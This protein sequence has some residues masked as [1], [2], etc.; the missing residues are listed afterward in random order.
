MALILLIVC[1]ILMVF[2]VVMSIR[3][4]LVYQYRTEALSMVSDMAKLLINNK[5]I[6]DIKK[7]RWEEFYDFRDSHGSYNRQMFTLTKWRF[8]DF[9]PNFWLNLWDMREEMMEGED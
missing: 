2:A 7:N 8:K 3:N 5:S 6:D 9:Y 1:G 4:N